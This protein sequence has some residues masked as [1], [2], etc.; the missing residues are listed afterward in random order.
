V[1]ARQPLA[2]THSSGPIAPVASPPE[3]LHQA[4]FQRHSAGQEETVGHFS[5]KRPQPGQKTEPAVTSNHPVSPSARSLEA[6]IR[7]LSRQLAL[8]WAGHLRWRGVTYRISGPWDV[9]LLDYRPYKS[10]PQV[11]DATV[12]S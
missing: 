10:L 7:C 8:V 1:A 12:S 9:Q 5:A 2:L 11:A 4:N 6:V 3:I